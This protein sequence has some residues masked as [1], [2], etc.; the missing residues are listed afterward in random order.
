MAKILILG[1]GISGHVAASHLR[2]KLDKTHE[3]VVVSPNSNYH[4]FPP[5]YGWALAE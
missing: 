5:I 2:R 4:G 1:A 3:V